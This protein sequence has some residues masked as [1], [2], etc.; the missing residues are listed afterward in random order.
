MNSAVGN[1]WIYSPTV[2]ICNAPMNL[3][4]AILT[5]SDRSAAGQRLDAT[6]PALAQILHDQGWTVTRQDIVADETR[7]IQEKLIAWAD[8][9]EIDVILTNGGTGFSRRDVT[10]EATQAV[11]ERNAPGIAEAMRAESL[12]KTPHA[13]LSRGVAGI[14]GQTLV[15][16]LPG[17]PKAALENL[18]IILPIFSHAVQLLAEDPQAE[19]GHR[20]D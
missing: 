6:G 4:I 3:R 12:K 16:N 8:S 9:G 19:A 1:A 5:V 14:R 10:P 20:Y 7:Q 15:I 2:K 18:L 17:S 11:L 13:M